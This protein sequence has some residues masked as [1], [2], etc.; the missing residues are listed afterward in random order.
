MK[1][2]CKG[3]ITHK[4]CEE[5]EDCADRM[6]IECRPAALRAAVADGVTCGSFFQDEWAEIITHEFVSQCDLTTSLPIDK[7]RELWFKYVSDWVNRPETPHFTK[8]I[9]ESKRAGAATLVTLV[10]SAEYKRWY[11]E[12]RGDSCLFFVPQGT[13]NEP[14]KWTAIT[15]KTFGNEPDYY[16]SYFGMDKGIII[17]ARNIVKPGTFYIM[18]DALSKWLYDQKE[19]ALDII[20]GWDNQQ[21]FEESIEQLRDSDMLGDDDSTILIIKIEADDNESFIYEDINVTNINDLI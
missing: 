2:S 6:A 12:S 1:I 7:C 10:V 21:M 11:A 3:F 20:N 4:Q 14:N 16:A 19:K 17:S 5:Y 15:P 8:E 9:F 13:E 18:T